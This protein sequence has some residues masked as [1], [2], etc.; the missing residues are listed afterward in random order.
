MVHTKLGEKCKRKRG[1]Y[2]EGERLEASLEG[3]QRGE[4]AKRGRI[5]V[6]KRS[7]SQYH[8]LYDRGYW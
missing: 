4:E 5:Y 8:E 3:A 7:A 6:E 2:S 1:A